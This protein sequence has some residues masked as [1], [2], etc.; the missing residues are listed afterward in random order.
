MRSRCVLEKSP[1]DRAHADVFRYAGNP[2]SQRTQAAD[3]EIDLHAGTRCAVQRLDGLRVH[4]RIHLG[5]DPAG[6]T[7]GG[8]ERLAL[9]LLHHRG[10]QAER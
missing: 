5:D 2:G 4:Q 10:V 3:D 7:S 8:N 1:D 9:D 6:T